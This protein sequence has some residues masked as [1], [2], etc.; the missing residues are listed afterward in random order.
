M[1]PSFPGASIAAGVVLLLIFSYSAPL[2]AQSVQAAKLAGLPRTVHVVVSVDSTALAAGINGDT[3]QR[4]LESSLRAA[5]FNVS[6]LYGGSYLL[7]EVHAF[8][9]HATNMVVYDLGLEY[10]TFAVPSRRLSE[11]LDAHRA[12]AGK[13]I[14]TSELERVMAG[15]VDVPVYRRAVYGVG[16]R[17]RNEASGVTGYA[18]RN[19]ETF[20]TD[21]RAANLGAG[22][23]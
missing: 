9:V 12:G 2:R 20:V 21:F 23:Q 17:G 11:L 18:L 8:Q 1:V 5:G 7:F 16:G 13:E 4:N 3:L 10:H 15:S 19:L 22:P 14:P 6:S